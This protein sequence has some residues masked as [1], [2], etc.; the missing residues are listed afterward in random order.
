MPGDLKSMLTKVTSS[1][2][3]KKYFFAYA[4]GKRKDGAG[5]GE[6]VVSVK[7]LK[8]PDIEEELVACKDF[9]E[10][11]CWTGQ[12]PDDEKTVYFQARGKKLSSMLVTKMKLTAKS[13]LGKQY[14][15][16]LPSPEEEARS[17]SLKDDDDDNL[18]TSA[19]PQTTPKTVDEGAKDRKP[20]ISLPDTKA[21]GM[22]DADEAIAKGD[23]A[24]IKK[25]YR[26]S[27]TTT[28]KEKA[29]L[30][31][32]LI[33]SKAG[34]KVLS[35]N[36]DLGGIILSAADPSALKQV[37]LDEMLGNKKNDVVGE[38]L[39]WLSKKEK[40]NPG[41]ELN[42][43]NKVDPELFKHLVKQIEPAVWNDTGAS[44]G[45]KKRGLAARVCNGLWNK[46]NFDLICDAIDAGVDT[47]QP[48]NVGDNSMGGDEGVWSGF[49]QPLEHVLGKYLQEV[50][51]KQRIEKE[52]ENRK[53][54]GEA[55]LA[56]SPDTKREGK[57]KGAE[58]IFAHLE[59]SG[60]GS[61]VTSWETVANSKMIKMFEDSPGTIWGFE[62]VRMP[63]VQAAHGTPGGD[64]PLRMIELWEAIEKEALT[65]DG[66]ANLLKDPKAASEKYVAGAIT[67]ISEGDSKYVPIDLAE[68]GRFYE[69]FK[70]QATS[71]LIEFA[72]QL[73]K[74]TFADPA[75]DAS[76]KKQKAPEGSKRAFLTVS[77]IAGADPGKLMGGFAC[78]AGIWWAKQQK[79]KI[80][81]CLDGIN[82]DDVCNYKRVKNAAIDDFIASSASGAVAKPHMEVITL[83]ELREIIKNWSS[84]KDTV[85]FIRKGQ[86]IEGGALAASIKEWTDK[87]TEANKVAGRRPAPPLKNFQTQLD[88]LD[89]S[90]VGKLTAAKEG[91]KDARDIVKKSGYLKKI[92]ATR[93][94]IALKF[95][96]SRCQILFNYGLIVDSLPAKAATLH[97]ELLKPKVNTDAVGAAARAATTAIAQCNAAFRQSLT[98]ALVGRAIRARG[99]A[100]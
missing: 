61:V 62:D 99:Q 42:R 66:Y 77:D 33:G 95:V 57:I 14:D 59:K 23:A 88:A 38:S 37:D 87:M 70:K 54:T 9:F 28:P 46:F 52:N 20:A 24:A 69:E 8:K 78:K 30:R 3:K 55:P 89:P 84:L 7:K 100:K 27:T 34:W 65:P 18:A 79:E 82:M 76:G 60:K 75:L 29:A 63:F 40:V 15:F 81:Y 91:D 53:S 47:S 4:T 1:G 31:D 68:Q 39:I 16:Q 43:D 58:R 21:T 35:E 83:V 36:A 51:E 50:G 13:V 90:L 25:I 74:G 97:A 12:G 92:S 85:V 73:P 44:I 71:F 56:W 93:P 11:Q 26:G 22:P 10:G 94:E 19:S 80:Y 17:V 86:P 72:S 45:A 64:R 2:G 32:A 98:D 67:R 49:V 6:L 48:F 96:M 41:Q 5:E